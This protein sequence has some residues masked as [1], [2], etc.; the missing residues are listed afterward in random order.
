MV[1]LSMPSTF[2]VRCSWELGGRQR[3]TVFIL[4][5]DHLVT[6]D[7]ICMMTKWSDHLVTGH[8]ELPFH[9]RG[10]FATWTHSS[11]QSHVALGI[12]RSTEF[13]I[14]YLAWIHNWIFYFVKCILVY[15][16]IHLYLCWLQ[17][18]LIKS[19]VANFSS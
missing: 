2:C 16:V 18:W 8:K 7:Q 10:C 6:D 11:F 5:F 19:P 3:N 4:W 17:R 1:R 13:W 9:H 14:F 15:S 12:W